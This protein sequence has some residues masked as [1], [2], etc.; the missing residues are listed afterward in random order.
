MKNIIEILEG[1]FDETGGIDANVGKWEPVVDL[2]I[3]VIKSSDWDDHH[4]YLKIKLERTWED[5]L[6]M[7]KKIKPLKYKKSDRTLWKQPFIGFG[8][9]MQTKEIVN[10]YFINGVKEYK[11]SS[12]SPVKVSGIMLSR[13]RIFVEAAQYDFLGDTGYQAYAC[14]EVVID[15]IMDVVKDK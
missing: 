5:V 11:T 2:V 14:P 8:T 12:K 3:N 6:A 15:M 9:N 4:M 1:L 13:D 10:V 7:V